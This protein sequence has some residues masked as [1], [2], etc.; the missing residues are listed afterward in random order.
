GGFMTFTAMS[1]NGCKTGTTVSITKSAPKKTRKARRKVRV[2]YSEAAIV[3]PPPGFAVR[4]VAATCRPPNGNLSQ[5]SDSRESRD[6]RLSNEAKLFQSLHFPFAI[7][8]ECCSINGKW[9]MT[10]SG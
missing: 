3:R 6:R 2:K 1:G 10:V 8:E 4:G 5:G 9:K 7:V